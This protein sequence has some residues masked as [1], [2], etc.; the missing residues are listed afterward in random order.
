[1]DW[2]CGA[3]SAG[4]APTLL[5]CEGV[6]AGVSSCLLL[7]VNVKV[8]FVSHARLRVP[9]RCCEARDGPHTLQNSING[10][11]VRRYLPLCCVPACG[12]AVVRRRCWGGCMAKGH[13]RRDGSDQV[14]AESRHMGSS[15][16]LEL[17]TRWMVAAGWDNGRA[18]RACRATT[19]AETRQAGRLWP[20]DVDGP[21]GSHVQVVLARGTNRRLAEMVLVAFTARTEDERRCRSWVS[22]GH[23]QYIFVRG[24]LLSR[25][26]P[27]QRLRRVSVSVVCEKRSSRPTRGR[28]APIHP[29]STLPQVVTRRTTSRNS[30]RAADDEQYHRCLELLYAIPP[31]SHHPTTSPITN[32]TT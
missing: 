24:R 28:I 5:W 19:R 14:A 4:T 12:R 2:W 18:E 23:T 11:S 26:T 27:I 20:V 22:T 8:W 32:G 21:P 16:S 13:N 31:S 25:E 15:T 30:C 6:G 10:L 17:E 29:R 3:R 1:M 9:D 7:H